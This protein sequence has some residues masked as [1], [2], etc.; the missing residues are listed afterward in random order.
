MG[1]GRKVTSGVTELSR[2]KVHTCDLVAP[3]T[4]LII[5]LSINLS[6][7]LIR[8]PKSLLSIISKAFKYSLSEY[9][10]SGVSLSHRKKNITQ[11][12]TH[13]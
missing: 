8:E 2:A 10:T 4:F 1:G 5:N 11:F 9:I 3:L 6:R 13:Q 12:L 7:V